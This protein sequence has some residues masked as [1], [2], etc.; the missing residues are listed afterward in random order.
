MSLHWLAAFKTS[1]LLAEILASSARCRWLAKVLL[2]R[3]LLLNVSSYHILVLV[4]RPLVLHIIFRTAHVYVRPVILLLCLHIGVVNV[5]IVFKTV[6]VG[7]RPVKLLLALHSVIGLHVCT[8]I[9]LCVLKTIYVGDRP[10][11]LLLSLHVIVVVP[12]LIVNLVAIDINMR[13]HCMTYT[14]YIA[15]GRYGDR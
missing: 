12:L 1:W 15:R 11:N 9:V 4:V 6:N 10:V 7:G 8:V 2:S 14:I 13:R 3:H 5:L